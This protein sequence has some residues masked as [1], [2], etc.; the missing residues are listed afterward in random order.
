MSQSHRVPSVVGPM[1]TWFD[2]PVKLYVRDQ[3]GRILRDEPQRPG[4]DV[5]ERLRI[6]WQNYQ[7]Q[8]WEV[9][10]LYPGA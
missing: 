5:R 8:G 4:S 1:P 10:D 7:L 6:A 9:D 2:T 3:F